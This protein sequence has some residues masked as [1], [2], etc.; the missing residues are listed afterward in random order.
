VPEKD[1]VSASGHRVRSIAGQEVLVDPEGFLLDV[2]QWN[3]EVALT[4]ALEKGLKDLSE[5]Q[6]RVIRLLREYYLS[7][8]KPPLNRELKAG[9][10]LSLRELD[11]LFP[12]GI[13]QAARLLAGL[14]NPRTCL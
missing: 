2:N 5:M 10:G 4:L 13:R 7:N 9:T 6:W 12:G 11:A 14:P 8:G 1:Q 3:E